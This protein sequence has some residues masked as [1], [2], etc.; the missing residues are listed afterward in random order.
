VLED[1]RF[2]FLEFFFLKRMNPTINNKVKTK[3]PTTHPTI[4]PTIFLSKKKIFFGSVISEG[5]KENEN[6]KGN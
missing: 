6:E 2:A 3:N 1:I 5:K 4:I